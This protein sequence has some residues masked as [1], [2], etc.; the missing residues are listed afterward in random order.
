MSLLLL[1][2]RPLIV[3]LTF[4]TLLHLLAVH[5]KRGMCDAGSVMDYAK[6]HM[7]YRWEKLQSIVAGSPR[8]QLQV[9][10]L[11]I[12]HAFN[13]PICHS[14]ASVDILTFCICAVE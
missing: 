4:A 1:I 13:Q 10:P 5:L 2:V 3:F 8:L 9:S 12:P 6:Q 14:T 11:D 7:Q